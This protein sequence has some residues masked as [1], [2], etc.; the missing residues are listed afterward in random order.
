MAAQNSTIARSRPKAG[1]NPGT[2][3]AFICVGQFMVFMDVSIVNLALPSI[4]R[5]LGMSAVS[6]NYVITAYSTVLG[7]L[8]LLGGRLA[9]TFGRRRMLQAGLAVFAAALA[10]RVVPESK[11]A[12]QRRPFDVAGA[13]AL[14][15]GL[16]LL[17]FTLGQATRVGWGATRT[18][19][20][21]AGVAVLL[22]A[23]L[24]I[25]SR[26]ASPMMP[27]RIFRLETSRTANLSAVL[28]FGTFSAMF[29]FASIFMQRV[30]G[31]TPI[32]AG[33]AYVPLAVCVAA[34]AGIASGLVTKMAARP[35]LSRPAPGRPDDAARKPIEEHQRGS[36]KLRARSRSPARAQP[37]AL[38]RKAA[39][40][41]QRNGQI[42]LRDLAVDCR[43]PKLCRRL[44]P[45]ASWALLAIENHRSQIVKVSAVNPYMV[46]TTIGHPLVITPRWAT[47]PGSSTACNQSRSAR[48]TRT[49]AL[50]LVRRGAVAP[51]RTREALGGCWPMRVRACTLR[52]G[53]S[54]R[55]C[56]GKK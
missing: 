28:V 31:Y 17:I 55:Y 44:W 8:L 38:R 5:G 25:E 4:Q 6:L 39:K 14:T 26:A 35:V 20:S 16:L 18:V 11:A 43:A 32:K 2:I 47:S 45:A 19:A 46:G 41:A 34:G 22:A 1:V 53:T 51:G 10:P 21:L 33:F 48:S 54:R 15:S 24:V 7:G 27:L 52:Q 29:F 37:I 23:F 3:L 30:Y 50:P 9:D 49:R 12:D 40:T 13:A 42:P 56:Q 36:G